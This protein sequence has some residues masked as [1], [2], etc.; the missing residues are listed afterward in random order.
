MRNNKP[1]IHPAIQA[2]V[3][4]F[5]K[6]E[7]DVKKAS[8]GRDLRILYEKFGNYCANLGIVHAFGNISFSNDVCDEDFRINL[9]SNIDMAKNVCISK[10]DGLSSESSLTINNTN[11][12]EQT[13]GITINLKEDLRKSLTGEQY[14]VLIELINNKADK[15]TLFEKI[16]EFGIDVASRVLSTIITNQLM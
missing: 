13:Q 16:K 2:R 1:L 15:K 9:L 11:Q 10:R 3:D 14:D 4:F 12:Q 8:V 7:D 5:E 6:I